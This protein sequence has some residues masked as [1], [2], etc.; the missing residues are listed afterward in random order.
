MTFDNWLKS[1]EFVLRRRYKVKEISWGDS[2]LK[3][4]FETNFTYCL[5]NYELKHL[6]EQR[7]MELIDKL[8]T[9]IENTYV[10]QIMNL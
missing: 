10:K 9:S 4:R 3:I 8:Y 5:N 7:D 1:V 6:Y 2:G